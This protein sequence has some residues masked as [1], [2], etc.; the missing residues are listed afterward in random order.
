MAWLA[1]RLQVVEIISAASGFRLD[2]I[3]LI[4]RCHTTL[5]Q[6]GLA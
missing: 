2:V 3:D 4:G 6:T 1:K 5:T